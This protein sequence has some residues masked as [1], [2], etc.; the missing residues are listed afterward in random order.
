MKEKVAREDVKPL[1]LR[2]QSGLGASPTAAGLNLK[3]I[4]VSVQEREQGRHEG[5]TEGA[6]GNTKGAVREQMDGTGLSARARRV[7]C[8]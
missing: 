2:R 4:T 3:G 8:Y 6:E 7:T 5:S 1:C